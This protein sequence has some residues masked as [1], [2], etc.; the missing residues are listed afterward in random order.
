MASPILKQ[1][2][3]CNLSDKPGFI[4]LSPAINTTALSISCDNQGVTWQTIV[5]D[6]HTAAT[7]EDIK[8]Q[9]ETNQSRSM[10]ST[11]NITPPVQNFPASVSDNQLVH[12]EQAVAK[13]EERL[14]ALKEGTME[15]MLLEMQLDS[16]KENIKTR[17]VIRSM[18]DLS[19]QNQTATQQLERNYTSINSTLQDLKTTNENQETNLT[20]MQKELKQVREKITTLTGIVDNQAM[21]IRHLQD[22]NENSDTQ[23]L[24]NNLIIQGL[25]V[26]KDDS[27]QN[28]KEI[29]TDFFSQTMKIR[30]N[31]AIRSALRLDRKDSAVQITLQSLK[32]KGLIFKNIKKIINVKNSQDQNYYINDQLTYEKQEEQRRFKMI[33]KANRNLQENERAKIT[34]KKGE[35]FIDQVKYQ[36]KIVF[37]S[38]TETLQPDS[39]DKIE[40]L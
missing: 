36:K 15:R 24:H 13:L 32:D 6:T 33:K 35:M 30:K 31:I 9:S 16:K 18:M 10:L 23:R 17:K 22:H 19:L 26:S 12:D 29:V 37:P 20:A 28:I 1:S 21:M 25:E 5:S 14:I 34:F 4:T 27:E 11:M 2:V 7:E 40:K 3:N 38:A 8:A 39:M